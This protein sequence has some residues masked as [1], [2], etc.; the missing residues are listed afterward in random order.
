MITDEHFENVGTLAKLLNSMQPQIYSRNQNVLPKFFNELKIRIGNMLRGFAKNMTIFDEFGLQYYGPIDGHN[1]KTLIRYLELIKN[2]K[3]PA[4]LHVITKKGKGYPPAENDLLGLW[5]GVDPFD[6][7][8]GE[9]TINMPPEIT[10][11]GKVV[12]IFA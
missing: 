4:V 8:T 7:V 1:I 6:Q 9:P 3:H 5:H 10:N 11:L 2:D 12:Q